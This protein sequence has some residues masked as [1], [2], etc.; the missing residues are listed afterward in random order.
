MSS[1]GRGKFHQKNLWNGSRGSLKSGSRDALDQTCD[2]NN[3]K[4]SPYSNSDAIDRPK[5]EQQYY[6]TKSQKPTERDD[7]PPPPAKPKHTNDFRLDDFRESSFPRAQQRP[8]P[9]QNT[10]KN[11]QN[12]SGRQSSEPRHDYPYY[13]QMPDYKNDRHR[14]TESSERYFRNGLGNPRKNGQGRF[15][16]P[17]NIEALPPRLQ[18]K[19]LLDNGLDINL[20]NKA[21][22]SSSSDRQPSHSTNK[23]INSKMGQSPPFR[24]DFYRVRSRSTDVSHNDQEYTSNTRQSNVNYAPHNNRGDGGSSDFRSSNRSLHQYE[25]G[26]SQPKSS[27]RRDH[28][29][30]YDTLK[31]SKSHKPWSR[32]SGGAGGNGSSEPP[33]RYK[34]YER[35]SGT[36]S[37]GRQSP[38]DKRDLTD[39]F[40]SLPI[41]IN[42]YSEPNA[43]FSTDEP[44]NF[45]SFETVFSR[46]AYL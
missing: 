29:R 2:E 26:Y 3:S 16:M 11:T 13:N 8:H 1:R 32:S 10:G 35:S 46:L 24:S 43:Q 45:V 30:P 20:L 19:F 5:R 41:T 17:P 22:P 18:K 9:M 31:S 27:N 7:M 38:F 21:T 25:S 14:E 15:K 23:Q 28:Q 33:D 34:T 37:T 4:Y 42:N 44:N 12:R 40:S 36:G 39:T 6:A